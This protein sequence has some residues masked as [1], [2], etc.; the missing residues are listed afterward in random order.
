MTEQNDWIEWA[1]G[2]CPVEEGKAV[3]VKYRDGGVRVFGNKENIGKFT[4]VWRHQ[5]A[6]STNDIIAY[7]VVA[8]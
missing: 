2:E 3:A 6:D 8:A 5:A 1:G 4:S 7:R